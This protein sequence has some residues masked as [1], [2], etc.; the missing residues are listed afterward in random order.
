MIKKKFIISVLLVLI[1]SSSIIVFAED[2]KKA[3]HVYKLEDIRIDDGE[4]TKEQLQDF[5]TYLNGEEILGTRNIICDLFGHSLEY[6]ATVYAVNHKV[7]ADAPR[8]V[9]TEYEV[10]SC[11]RCSYEEYRFVLSRRIFCCD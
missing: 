10:F 9:E 1:I 2:G 4:L 11:T 5:I 8:C 7:Y 3:E 6:T